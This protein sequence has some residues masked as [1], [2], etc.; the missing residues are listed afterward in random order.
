[1]RNV[2]RVKLQGGLGNQLFQYAIGRH[3][4]HEWG[5]KL[6]L[7]V[8]WFY[9]VHM[10]NGPT[11]RD[12]ALGPFVLNAKLVNQYKLEVI[13]EKILILIGLR[14]RLQVVNEISYNFHDY[15]FSYPRSISLNGYWQS[16][17]YFEKSNQLIIDD[18]SRLVPV[19]DLN[20]SMLQ[21]IRNTT[22]AICVHVR[23]GDYVCDRKT[24][25]YHG[26]CDLLYYDEAYK[27]LGFN[28][29]EC[30]VFVFSDEIE[31]VKKNLNFPCPVNCVDINDSNSV[32][33]D[34]MLM[35]ACNHF[36]IANSSLSWWAAWLGADRNKRIIAPIK[37]FADNKINTEDLIPSGWMLA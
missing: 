1:V 8:S 20:E 32:H 17:R 27:R 9:K 22:N 18:L 26:F 7:D 19:N 3:L 5:C 21:K 23:R 30:S 2:V 37:W 12:Y 4:S 25:E 24:S 13:Y 10:L 14:K 28:A 29:D 16:W 11:V 36:I 35:M 33:Q 34:L 31:W 15:E 6:E